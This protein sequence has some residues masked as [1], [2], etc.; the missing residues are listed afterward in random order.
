MFADVVLAADE[1]KCDSDF[2]GDDHL[3][4]VLRTSAVTAPQRQY[5]RRG[6]IFLLPSLSLKDPLWCF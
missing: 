2:L 1:E 5:F 4:D 6:K 3:V